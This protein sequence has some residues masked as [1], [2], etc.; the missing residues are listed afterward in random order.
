MTRLVVKVDQ[1]ERI[2]DRVAVK[3]TYVKER[4]WEND[5]AFWWQDNRELGVP[6]EVQLQMLAS[7]ATRKQDERHIVQFRGHHVDKEK[8]TFRIYME[9]LPCGDMSALI[10]A[11]RKPVY[12]DDGNTTSK[13]VML[14]LCL[15]CSTTEEM[16]RRMVY[17]L[18]AGKSLRSRYQKPSSGTS[19][20]KW[21]QACV[22]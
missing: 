2:E 4:I 19:F 10:S 13:T 18:S 7:S 6:R 12:V 9:Y 8:S 15:E 17:C 22:V 11:Q 1:F 20:S 16:P 3:E 5:P 21:Q 14:I